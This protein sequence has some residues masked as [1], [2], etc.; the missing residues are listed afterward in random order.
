MPAGV[1]LHGA[2][3]IVTHGNGH[4]RGYE[5]DRV[6]KRGGQTVIVLTMDHGLR[7]KG[8]ATEEVFF[9]QRKIKGRNTF[10]IP[11]AVSLVGRP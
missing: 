7:I 8:D 5:I 2:W 9:P 6:E 4:T 1:A 11:L 10:S 3:I